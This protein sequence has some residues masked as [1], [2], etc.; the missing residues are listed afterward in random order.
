MRSH[1]GTC[2]AL[3]I[4]GSS[5]CA[6]VGRRR[7]TPTVGFGGEGPMDA[8]AGG[9]F[10]PSTD[11]ASPL[12]G[13]NLSWFV[14]RVHRGGEVRPQTR[15]CR[16][17]PVRATRRSGRRPSRRHRRTA[18]RARAGSGPDHPPW[19]LAPGRR[20]DLG[21]WHGRSHTLSAL[22]ERA[23]RKV[24]RGGDQV[25]LERVGHLAVTKESDGR[26]EHVLER[27]GGAPTQG[28]D[29]VGD[30]L[31]RRT[32]PGPSEGGERATDRCCASLPDSWRPSQE[33]SAA[34]GTPTERTCADHVQVVQDDGLK[35]PCRASPG[36]RSAK[37]ALKSS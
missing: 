20:A 15:S 6:D 16:R 37:V 8:L 22:D 26:R 1:R 30:Q 17:G 32:T 29:D 21:S 34:P 14:M 23:V 27:G 4:V 28:D 36:S 5:L 2:L 19:R 12:R 11:A 24:T 18:R 9:S 10:A 31:A 35:A 3:K 13:V 7:R 25:V 33:T